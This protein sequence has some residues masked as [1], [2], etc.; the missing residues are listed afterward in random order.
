MSDCTTIIDKWSSELI[1]SDN[2]ENRS[3]ESLNEEVFDTACPNVSSTLYSP[4]WISGGDI[5]LQFEAL[6]MAGILT[7]N[8]LPEDCGRGEAK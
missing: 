2:R 4:N 8:R 1:N 5:R 3:S 7:L 6:I